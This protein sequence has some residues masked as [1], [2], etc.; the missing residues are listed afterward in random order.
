[1]RAVNARAVIWSP[2]WYIPILCVG[3]VLHLISLFDTRAFLIFVIVVT[4]TF[5]LV[6]VALNRR[7]DA[8][9]P[10]ILLPLTYTLYALG[11]LTVPTEFPQDVSIRYLS[12]QFLG[13]VSMLL[14]LHFGVPRSCSLNLAPVISQ[15]G[16]RTRSLLLATAIGLMLLSIPSIA[17]YFYS[18]GGVTGFLKVGWGGKFYL[19]SRES[20]IM[21]MGFE[22]WL[23]GAVLL[24]FYGLKFHSRTYLFGGIILYAIVAFIFLLFGRRNTL[25]YT[26]IFGITLFHYGHKRLSSRVVTLGI[27]VGIA[28]AQYYALARYYLPEGLIYALSKT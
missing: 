22:W 20:L 13:L 4:G 6:R 1:M 23:L 17:S 16:P 24:A 15:A 21:G 19:I 25:I 10:R 2:L 18:F 8:L 7:G 5:P 26:F 9:S 11:P 27:L 3:A 28:L 14:G 12:L